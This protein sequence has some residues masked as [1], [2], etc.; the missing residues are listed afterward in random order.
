MVLTGKAAAAIRLQI[1][2]G[3]I[4]ELHSNGKLSD[5]EFQRLMKGKK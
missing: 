4:K 5:N 1:K 2:I 3:L